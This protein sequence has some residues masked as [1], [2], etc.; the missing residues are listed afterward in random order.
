MNDD[1]NPDLVRK[2]VL[3]NFHR[4]ETLLG[5][6]NGF[7][8]T[9]APGNPVMFGL[10]GD[11]EIL[12]ELVDMDGDG[13]VDVLYVD[14]D[15]DVIG[16]RFNAGDFHIGD[17]E[18]LD[19]YDG[20]GGYVALDQQ[21]LAHVGITTVVADIDGDG[22][23]DFVGPCP[24]D[25]DLLRLHVKTGIGSGAAT[26]QELT[27]QQTTDIDFADLNGDGE[28]DIVHTSGAGYVEVFL[29]DGGSWT[30]AIN[31]FVDNVYRP[32]NGRIGDLDGNGIVDLV[33][34]SRTQ[35]A[36]GVHNGSSPLSFDAPTLLGVSGNPLAL[37]LLDVNED[38]DLDILVP[39]FGTG[40]MTWLGDGTGGFGPPI[41][42]PMPLTHHIRWDI[43]DVDGDGRID[44]VLASGSES[45]TEDG[46]LETALGDGTG[47]FALVTSEVVSPEFLNLRL[48]DLDRDGHLDLV[49]Q[50]GSMEL[51]LL[52]P[53]GGYQG[54]RAD[55]ASTAVRRGNGD[56]TFAAPFSGYELD[57]LHGLGF[58]DL[59][60]TLDAVVGP[61]EA[62]NQLTTIPWTPLGG[63]LAG[64]FGLP[65]LIGEGIPAPE[66]DVAVRVDGVL[67]NSTLA[68]VVGFAT[69]PLP[70]FGGTLVPD[71]D[72]LILGLPTG[73]AGFFQAGG[74][75]PADVPAGFQFWVQAWVTDPAGPQG[76]S[77]TNAVK[78]T[79]TTGP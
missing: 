27:G 68:L 71:L 76:F 46:R 13:H 50:N 64:S 75:L 69:Q 42:S 28:T 53:F 73:P 78:A 19:D 10:A 66:A 3:T 77:A 26:S 21:T 17:A 31:L 52:I 20:C 5:S 79:V 41:T 72:V 33:T 1:M 37:E 29:Q 70:F 51:D 57:W 30:P 45:G 62:P 35:N 12:H 44:V 14:L 24:L 8:T 9:Q 63:A 48:G 22:Y 65:S 59:G 36:I 16:T 74:A 23:Q 40:L 39:V 4:I 47:S 11:H 25:D 67:P 7:L 38:G 60:G 32:R 34:T 6:F 54:Y 43:G 58:L 2:R 15:D 18:A 55:V 56:G 61:Q 49:T